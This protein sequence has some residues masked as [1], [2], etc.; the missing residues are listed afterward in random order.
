MLAQ[1]AARVASELHFIIVGLAVILVCHLLR[2]GDV[3][4]IRRCDISTVRRISFYHSKC[5]NRWVTTLMG[6]WEAWC[7]ASRSPCIAVRPGRLP[8]AA[9]TAVLQSQM[10][11]LL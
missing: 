9:G 8:I 3:S 10:R 11:A 6:A 1:M 2:M 4:S 5:A 7:G